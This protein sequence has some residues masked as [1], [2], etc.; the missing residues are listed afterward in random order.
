MSIDKWIS[1]KGSK[2][3]R[4]REEAFNKLSTEEVQNLK[5]KKVRDLVKKKVPSKI[6]NSDLD[7]FLQEII[8]FNTW[9]NQRTY[10]KG[11]LEKIEMWIRN[12]NSKI[13]TGVT[14]GPIQS[15]INEKRKI[16]EKYKKLPLQ[17]LDEKIRIAL[18]KRIHG[19][20]KTTS[21]NYYL[22]KLK[23]IIQTKLAEAKYYE[24]LDKI[25]KL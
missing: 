24:I 12:L 8:E 21:D 5:K 18:N 11:D 19:G 6:E 9:I 2:E 20:K 4:R 16:I 17:L 23:T 10:L 14:Q 25:L 13:I 3:N 15:D 22:R 1:K 7:E